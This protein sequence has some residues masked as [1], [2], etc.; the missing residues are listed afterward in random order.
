MYEAPNVHVNPSS[1]SCNSCAL[2]NEVHGFVSLDC[3]KD[4]DWPLETLYQ[5]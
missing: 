2:Q 3:N 5:L 1:H 4:L